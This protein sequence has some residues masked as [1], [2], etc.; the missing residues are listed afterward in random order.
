L[1]SS[2]MTGILRTPNRQEQRLSHRH[3]QSSEASHANQYPNPILLNTRERVYEARITLQRHIQ[4]GLNITSIFTCM[5]TNPSW[6]LPRQHRDTTCPRT[7]SR[8]HSQCLPGLKLRYFLTAVRAYRYCL[9]VVLPR[10][11][12]VIFIQRQHYPLSILVLSG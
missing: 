8:P 4:C 5:Q 9:H 6:P 1:I 11:K 3:N 2:T 7:S 10:P 12:S